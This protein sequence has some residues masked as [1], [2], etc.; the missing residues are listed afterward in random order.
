MSGSPEQASSSPAVGA[1]GL[2]RTRDGSSAWCPLSTTSKSASARQLLRSLHT[3]VARMQPAHLSKAGPT[4]VHGRRSCRMA[5]PGAPALG[6][7]P[8]TRML[9][10]SGASCTCT[11]TLK[12]SAQSTLAPDGVITPPGGLREGLGPAA[13][14][15]DSKVAGLVLMEGQGGAEQRCWSLHFGLPACQTARCTH[16]RKSAQR[17]SPAEARMEMFP[18]Q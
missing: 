4:L 18:Q 14:R 12:S 5:A 10:N 3:L 16:A 13:S 11:V 7:A 17:M 2:A 8:S 6:S 9:L 1:R 15:H